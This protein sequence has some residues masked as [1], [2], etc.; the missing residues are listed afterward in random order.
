MCERYDGTL[1]VI[2]DR[3]TNDLIRG[4]VAGMGYPRFLIGASNNNVEFKWRWVDYSPVDYQNW[5]PS[6][7]TGFPFSKRTQCLIEPQKTRPE[8]PPLC[9]M[10]DNESG[11]WFTV[12]CSYA[13]ASILC[14]VRELFLVLA[15]DDPF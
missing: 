12:K 7:I 1:P 3:Q 5:A 4:I 8:D 15:Q 14:R 9:A 13:G 2:H 11:L 6:G 10:I